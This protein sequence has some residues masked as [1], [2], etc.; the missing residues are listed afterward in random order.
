LDAASARLRL[1]VKGNQVRGQ[2]R[3]PDAKEWRDAGQCDLPGNS[4]AKISL[5]FYQGPAGAEHWARV[6]EFRVR[7][8]A[9]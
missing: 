7:R 4:G 8:K 6:T 5:Q 1:F 2:F 9:N 3:A